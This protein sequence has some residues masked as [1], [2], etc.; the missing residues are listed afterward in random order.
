MNVLACGNFFA[1]ASRLRSFTS[2]SATMFSPA[3]AISPRFAP[4]LP[5]QPMMATF[6]LLFGDCARRNAGA[7]EAARMVDRKWRRDSWDMGIREISVQ[8][9]ATGQVGKHLTRAHHLS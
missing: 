7:A 3:A 6:S 1:A 9:A 4:P 2:Q 5:P 8:W